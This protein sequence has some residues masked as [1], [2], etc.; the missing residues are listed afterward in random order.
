MPGTSFFSW[1]K[2][3]VQNFLG[4]FVRDI[5]FI[6]FAAVSISYDVYF[7]TV[8]KAFKEI[9]YA[10]RSVHQVSD[11][12]ALIKGSEAIVVAVEIPLRY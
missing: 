12:R 5:V 7:E 4:P 10:L 3:P 8:S 6:P 11:K 1:P 2:L 9:G